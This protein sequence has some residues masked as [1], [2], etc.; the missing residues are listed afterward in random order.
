MMYLLVAETSTGQTI[1]Q[2]WV[3]AENL[4]EARG[5]FWKKLTTDQQDAVASI[6]DIDLKE[7]ENELES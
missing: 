3:R 4:N 6:E 1:A 2:M 7:S 5:K